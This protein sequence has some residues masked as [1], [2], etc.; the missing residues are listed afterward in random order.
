MC[1]PDE[2]LVEVV[3]VAYEMKPEARCDGIILVLASVLGGGE[4]L[5]F[6]LRSAPG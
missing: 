1:M 3:S 5:L 2:R 4:T 6:T